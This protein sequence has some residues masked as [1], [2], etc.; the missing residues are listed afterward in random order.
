MQT[1]DLGYKSAKTSALR[2]LDAWSPK[3]F[4]RLP[5]E[6][7]EYLCMFPRAC[8]KEKVYGLTLSRTRLCPLIPKT[9][10]CEPLNL[11]PIS[12]LPIA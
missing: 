2:V 1:Y 10:G 3:D 7:L 12:V 11:R 8:R 5:D 9:E 6:V 4:K